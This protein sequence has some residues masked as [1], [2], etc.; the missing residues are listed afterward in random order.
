MDGIWVPEV[1]NILG[2]ISQWMSINRNSIFNT[3]PCWPFEYQ[4]YSRVWPKVENSTAAFYVT[5][6]PDLLTMHVSLPTWTDA[7]PS[8]ILIPFVRP[9]VLEAQG[10][11]LSGVQLLGGGGVAWQLGDNGLTVLGN[12]GKSLKFVFVWRLTFTSSQGDVL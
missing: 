11:I 2:D 12:S 1:Q 3:V 7:V 6:S 8:E 9:A 5:C 4:P 10:R